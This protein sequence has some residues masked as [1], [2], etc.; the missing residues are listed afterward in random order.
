MARTF[1]FTQ[2]F[3]TNTAAAKPTKTV[4]MPKLSTIDNILNY[5][6]AFKTANDYNKAELFRFPKELLIKNM[7]LN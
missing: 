5:S 1:T 4:K 6:K 7:M 3:E 2:L